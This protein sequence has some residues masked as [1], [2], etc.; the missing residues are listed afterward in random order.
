MWAFRPKQR[1]PSGCF[2]RFGDG[3]HELANARGLGRVPVWEN[4]VIAQTPATSR[5]QTAERALALGLQWLDPALQ[6]RSQLSHATEGDESDMNDIVNE[7]QTLVGDHVEVMCSCEVGEPRQI[8]P[9]DGV[10]WIFL[11]RVSA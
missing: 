6:F 11:A 10:C 2:V 9:T 7:I 3:H 5:G 8:S 4:H 1:T